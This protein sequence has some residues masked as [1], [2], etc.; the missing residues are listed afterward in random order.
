MECKHEI[1]STILS[2]TTVLKKQQCV[3]GY[4][5]LLNTKQL[6][7]AFFQG[8]GLFFLDTLHPFFSFLSIAGF[9]CTDKISIVWKKSTTVLKFSLLSIS[10]TI[11]LSPVVLEVLNSLQTAQV[12]GCF[13]GVKDLSVNQYSSRPMILHLFSVQQWPLSQSNK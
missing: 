7:S 11:S 9:F 1:K 5:K 4:G 10:P 3:D 13:T 8:E 2:Q 12:K 6:S